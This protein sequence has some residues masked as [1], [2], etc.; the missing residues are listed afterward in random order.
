MF[1]ARGRIPI[2]VNKLQVPSVEWSNRPSDLY[3]LTQYLSDQCEK[4]LNWQVVSIKLPPEKW[5]NAPVTFLSSND[6]LSLT[7]KQKMHLKRY[8]DLGGL[9]LANA[10][11][12]SAEFSDSIR[13]LAAELYP[14]YEL[15]R[16]PKK[17][18]LYTCWRHIPDKEK[19]TIFSLS[20]GVR[21]LI[22]MPESDWGFAF[23]VDQEPGKTSTWD[24][25]A[26]VFAYATDRG[27]L[28]PRLVKPYIYRKGRGYGGEITVGRASYEGNWLPEP[29]A[30]DLQS[31][32]VFNK[33]GLNVNV[34]PASGERV[35]S[36]NQ[37]GNCDYPIVHLTGTH[38]INLT[39]RQRRSIQRYVERG[40]HDLD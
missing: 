32:D 12:G 28:D 3:S 38:A 37:I 21:E 30:W 14:Q 34:T 16:I 10:D 11:G 7:D 13:A 40:W 26:N 9:L 35:L 18:P 8:L 20:N 36:L 39:E 17:H 6:P 27:A 19:Q 2:W 25:M 29:E 1:L 33:T 15:K 5:L 23:Q 31:N 4:E 24:L 22:I